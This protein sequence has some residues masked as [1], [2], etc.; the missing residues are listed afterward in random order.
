MASYYAID[1]TG[2]FLMKLPWEFRSLWS[3]WELVASGRKSL[4]YS[5]SGKDIENIR[6]QSM[7][8]TIVIFLPRLNN[9]F[10][11]NLTIIS[12]LNRFYRVI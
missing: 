4:E 10:F 7:Y 1:T 12:Q 5:G 8:I 11:D 3:V 2:L 9:Y 6:N